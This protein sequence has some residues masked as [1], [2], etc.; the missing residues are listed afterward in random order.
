MSKYFKPEEFRCKDGSTHPEYEGGVHPGLLLVLDDIREKFG[1][2]I[3][4]NSGYRSPEHNRRVGGAPRSYHVRGMAADIRPR[5]GKD[6]E[7]ELRR[8]KIIANRRCKGG[9][10]F[11]PSFVHVDLGPE[12]R[13]NG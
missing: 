10:G 4:V 7:A 2:P 5:H 12:R 8:L 9:V 13:W 11:Y 1:K 3:L 6:F